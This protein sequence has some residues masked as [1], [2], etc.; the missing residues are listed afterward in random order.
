[1]TVYV[2]RNSGDRILLITPEYWIAKMIMTE[3]YEMCGIDEFEFGE[4]FK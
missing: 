4:W 1:M 2:V 3:S